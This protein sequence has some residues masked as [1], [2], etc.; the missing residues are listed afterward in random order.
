MVLI[1]SMPLIAGPV[2]QP[3]FGWMRSGTRHETWQQKLG[4]A[5]WHSWKESFC[6]WPRSLGMPQSRASGMSCSTVREQ[7]VGEDGLS[8]SHTW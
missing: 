3:D 5:G 7:G 8:S 1:N 2:L 6:L 4:H